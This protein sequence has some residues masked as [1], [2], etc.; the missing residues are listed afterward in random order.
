[1]STLSICQVSV[2]TSRPGAAESGGVAAGVGCGG[3]QVPRRGGAVL[4]RVGGLAAAGSNA[5][6]KQPLNQD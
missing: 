1:M 5:A 4:L 6:N 3:F 2:S